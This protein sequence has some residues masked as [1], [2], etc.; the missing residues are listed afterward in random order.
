MIAPIDKVEGGPGAEELVDRSEK[1]EP[2]ER[3][4]S[5]LEKEHRQV[6]AIE[7]VGA[8]GARLLGWMEG[9]AQEHETSNTGKGR[10]G[11]GGRR[12][13]AAERLAAGHERQAGR[14]RRGPFDRR[15][16]GG[17]QHGGGSGLPPPA[18]I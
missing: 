4:A 2:G 5:A 17:L 11:G 15:P 7:M 10:R 3:V 16:D 9:K 6:Y 1:I 18:S 14:H 12:H 8:P 13:P